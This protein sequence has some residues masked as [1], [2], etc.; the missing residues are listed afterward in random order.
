MIPFAP[1]FAIHI[2]DGVLSAPWLA[3]GFA[4]A[5]V[6]ALLGAYRVRDEEIPRIALL[7]AAFFVASL[8]HVRAGPTSVH[9]L[10]NGLIGV[11]LGRRAGLAILV[12]LFLQAVLI[13]HGGFLSLGVNTCVMALPALAASVAFTGLRSLPWLRF[14]VVRTALVTIGT[15]VAVLALEF[16]VIVIVTNS[17]HGDS[18]LRRIQLD[19]AVR[20][21]LHPAVLIGACVIAFTA[22]WKQ[23]RMERTPEFTLGLL[24]G[25]GAVVL[26]ALLNSLVLLLGGV[27]DWR[28]LALFVLAAHLPLAVVEG[29]VVGFAVSFL[30]RVKPEMLGLPGCES[31]WSDAGWQPKSAPAE[32]VTTPPGIK[33]SENGMSRNLSALSSKPPVL[34]LLAAAG[35]LLTAAPAFA[36]RLKADYKVLPNE[37]KVKIE[38]W[39]ESGDAPKNATVQVYRSDERLLIEGKLNADGVFVFP[40]EEADELRVVVNAPGGHR[41]QLK[42]PKAALEGKG[43][44]K[45]PEEET[46][47]TKDDGGRFANRE[48]HTSIKDVVLGVTFLFSAAGLALSV[49]NTRVLGEIKQRLNE[50]R[51]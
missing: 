16:G 46:S 18:V 47:A 13:G 7:T 39:F 1:I 29:V 26:T 9:L 19:D 10:L 33:P 6:L 32:T 43:D 27:E 14:P 41:E 24:V 44:S 48:S 40:F 51:A 3:G 11:M 38:G 50:P 45:K 36:H 28:S 20:M 35:L 2:S 31:P 34:M 15:A 25:A 5:A 49:R 17:W 42:I 21:L 30:A 22:S 4:G 37:H 8:L 12:G 23:R